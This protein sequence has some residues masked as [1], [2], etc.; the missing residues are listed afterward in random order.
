[1]NKEV[2]GL[3]IHKGCEL[4]TGF[5]VNKK[6]IMT[7]E[8]LFNEVNNRGVDE[9]IYIN[10]KN[11][12]LEKKAKLIYS[13]REIDIAILELEEVLEQEISY[14][15]LL[16]TITLQEGER[17]ETE[18]YPINRS[19]EDESQRLKGE[20]EDINDR[21]VIDLE[22]T[23]NNQDPGADWEGLSGAPVVIEGVICG[24]IIR[25]NKEAQINT[26]VKAISIEKIFNF[27][28]ENDSDI[29]TYF[30]VDKDNILTQRMSGF[31]K[32]CEDIFNKYE[33]HDSNFK[34]SILILKSIGCLEEVYNHIEWFLNDYATTLEQILNVSKQDNLISQRKAESAIKDAAKIVKDKM[35][36]EDKEFLMLLWIIMEGYFQTP[37]IG[38][39][40]SFL[41]MEHSRDIYVDENQIIFFAGY[42]S[43]ENDIVKCIEGVL[44]EI[45]RE[46]SDQSDIDLSYLIKWDHVAINYLDHIST[47]KIHEHRNSKKINHYTL[48]IVAL[49]SHS[50]DIFQILSGNLDEK[51]YITL[52][53]R[54][55]KEKLEVYLLE[56]NQMIKKYKWLEQIKIDWILVPIEEK[57][58]V[59]DSLA[60]KLG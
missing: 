40:L 45:D 33:Y 46:L 42:T 41:N 35:I 7:A 49:C 44:E 9:E 36:K 23:I 55:Y 39:M 30:K 31:K 54:M 20:I 53:E 2:V 28:Y 32:L 48:Q 13:S 47:L 26:T 3:V 18:G 59:K 38:K 11:I 27:L 52:S 57:A 16:N 19:K 43:L 51:T 4:G 25:D 15:R 22:L 14:H 24:V 58:K 8:H 6:Y 60:E 56:I 29:L 12:G 34:S 37:R 1:M 5:L 10:L 17:W 21:G 50:T